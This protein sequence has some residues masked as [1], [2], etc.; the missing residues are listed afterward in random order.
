MKTLKVYRMGQNNTKKFFP[1]LALDKFLMACYNG[2]T[3][4]GDNVLV[5]CPRSVGQPPLSLRD[6]SPPPGEI[7]A[8]GRQHAIKNSGAQRNSCQGSRACERQR[9][10]IF[11]TDTTARLR[12]RKQNCP[13]RSPPAQ[14][15][16]LY[17]TAFHER[18]QSLK[19]NKFL[20][21]MTDER[22]LLLGHL[23]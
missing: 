9:E 18:H 10:K 23:F 8:I 6:T 12:G 15:K 3:D 11:C 7:T 20:H 5:A 2:K 14:G 4:G 21:K 22:T 17:Y 16:S 1:M 13:L 19:F